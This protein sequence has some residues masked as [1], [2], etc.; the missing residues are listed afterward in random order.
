MRNITHKSLILIAVAG[1]AACSS[2]PYVPP[3][4]YPLVTVHL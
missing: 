3:T 4:E 1:L 2:T